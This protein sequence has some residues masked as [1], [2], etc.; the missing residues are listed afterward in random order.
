MGISAKWFVTK[1]NPDVFEITKRKF[2]NV[3]QGVAPPEIHLLKEDTE[4]YEKWCLYNAERYWMEDTFKSLDVAIIDDP[5]RSG[6]SSF[7]D[8]FD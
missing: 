2:H 4:L 1:P 8:P 7:Y 6:L 3:L 5:Q